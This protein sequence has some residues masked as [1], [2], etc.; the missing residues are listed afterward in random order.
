MIHKCEECGNV[1]G[2]DGDLLYGCSHHPVVTKYYKVPVDL[3]KKF[4]YKVKINVK[5]YPD[6]NRD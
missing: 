4:K 1:Y 3:F 5:T 6:D 2:T